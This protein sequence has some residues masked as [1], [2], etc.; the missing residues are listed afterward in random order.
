MP[1]HDLSRG[2]GQHLASAHGNPASCH[3]VVKAFFTASAG[4]ITAI[5]ICQPETHLAVE[6]SMTGG[7]CGP[8]RISFFDVNAAV[9]QVMGPDGVDTERAASYFAQMLRDAQSESGG[10]AIRIYGEMSDLL[11]RQ[12]KYAAALQL[13]GLADLLLSADPQASILCGYSTKNFENDEGLAHFGKICAAHNDVIRAESFVASLRGPAAKQAGPDLTPGVGETGTVARP[14]SKRNVYL[15]ED[16]PSVRNAILRFLQAKEFDVL[17]FETAEAFLAHLPG[18]A[19]GSLI[20]DVQLPGI[21]GFDLL[22]RMACD[23][24]GWPAVVFSGAHEDQG[25]AA[26]AAPHRYL[27]KPFDPDA[28]VRALQLAVD[29]PPSGSGRS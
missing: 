4:R 14:V 12:K 15:V 28:L 26:L 10:G 3:E 13:E 24:I 16:D 29:E 18:L 5:M 21:S 27:R 20:L 1:V 23:G 22:N 25:A 17:A 19:P 11:C 8:A 6:K 9:S 2:S 7:K